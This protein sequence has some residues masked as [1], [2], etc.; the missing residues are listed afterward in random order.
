MNFLMVFSPE[1]LKNAPHSYLASL[2]LAA[3]DEVGFSR[4]MTR[5]F[6]NI[7]IIRVKEALAN[8][9][10]TR[11]IV[12]LGKS[13]VIMREKPTSSCAARLSEAR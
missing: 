3:Q 10:L 2:S 6:P 7:T 12:I 4:I 5:D 1:P 13:R 11:I 8:A 9:S